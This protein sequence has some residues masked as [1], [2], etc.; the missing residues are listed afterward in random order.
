MERTSRRIEKEETL[1]KK[2]E[3]KYPPGATPLTDEAIKGLIPG[4]IT[5]QGELNEL[6]QKNIQNALVWVS[7]TKVSDPLEIKFIYELHRRMFNDVW[8]WAGQTRRHNTQPGVDWQQI[9]PRLIELLKDVPVWLEAQTYSFDE[10]A[11]RFHHRLV[12]IHCFAN[13]NGR[14]ARMLTD[15]F[16]EHHGREQFSWGTKSYIDSM[17]KADGDRRKK[18]IQALRL[19]DQQDYGPLLK[20]V[21][22]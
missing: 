3:L 5:T 20:F 14:H 21:R 2:L 15:I 16:I 10:I 6:E 12:H 11:A 18:Y 4:Y 8:S 1:M 9:M 7:R 13:G 19:A 17:E 22:S